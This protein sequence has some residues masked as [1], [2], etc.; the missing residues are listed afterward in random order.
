MGDFVMRYIVTVRDGLSVEV[1]EEGV[2]HLVSRDGAELLAVTADTAQL[3][4]QHDWP[5]PDP[6]ELGL[7][8]EVLPGDEA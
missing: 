6:R 8:C 5:R 2:R 1:R 4:L 3:L 7:S